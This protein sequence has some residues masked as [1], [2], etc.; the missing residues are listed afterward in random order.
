MASTD[1]YEMEQLLRDWEDD[2]LIAE[3]MYNALGETPPEPC[4][5]NWKQFRKFLLGSRPGT[6]FDL[7]RFGFGGDN[8]RANV[9]EHLEPFINISA[10]GGVRAYGASQNTT[11]MMLLRWIACSKR[12]FTISNQMQDQ[13]ESIDLGNIRFSDVVFP[14][15]S[16]G[17][18]FARPVVS[19]SDPTAQTSFVLVSDWFK[20][21]TEG[22]PINTMTMEELT[23]IV[24]LPPSL[25]Q[26]LALTDA[27]KNKLQRLQRTGTDRQRQAYILKLMDQHQREHKKVAS[28]VDSWIWNSKRDITVEELLSRLSKDFTD[29]ASRQIKAIRLVVNL[30]L[31][32]QSLPV[33][34]EESEG[35]LWHK[36]QAQSSE[37]KASAISDETLVCHIDGEHIIR[38]MIHR[39]TE[40]TGKSSSSIMPH[41]RRAHKRRPRGKGNDPTAEKTVK[42]RH[43]LVL[44]HLLPDGEA[45]HGAHSIV[46]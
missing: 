14:F 45:V 29:D 20:L 37:R 43:T 34:Y 24:T 7:T 5:R 2:K 30:C 46:K 31:Y 16:F 36:Q 21:A 3:A 15:P 25:T 8:F 9:Q 42:V 23:S 6:M 41:W 39:N 18:R 11:G 4:V 33:E 27:Q 1:A 10:D 17:V 26:Y 13:F 19:V 28:H 38:E 40:T 44:G 22:L 35:K 12:L 32:L